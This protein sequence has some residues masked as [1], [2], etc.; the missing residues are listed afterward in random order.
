MVSKKSPSEQKKFIKDNIDFDFYKVLF[1]PVRIEIL[2]YLITNGTKNISEISE[3]F[4]QD[5]SVISRHLDLMY[6][7]NI[8]KKNKENR[9]VYYEANNNFVVNKFDETSSS[10]K[11]MMSCLLSED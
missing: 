8:V 6:R 4:T 3:N 2:L 9:N 7:Y 10:L 11:K 1:D 5:R